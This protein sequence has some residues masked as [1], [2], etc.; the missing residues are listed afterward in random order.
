MNP[1][2]ALVA[3]STAPHRQ[4][5]TVRRSTAA[6]PATVRRI[7]EL[8]LTPGATIQVLNRSSSALIVSTRGSRVA[9]GLPLASS[10]LVEVSERLS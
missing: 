10:I 1:T 7:A 9:I 8:G 3:L 4:P 2:G 5:I 6:E